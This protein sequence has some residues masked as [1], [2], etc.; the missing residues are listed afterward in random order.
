VVASALLAPVCALFG[1]GL[2]VLIRH[3]ATTIGG[4]IFGLLL[5]PVL[6]SSN[7]PWSVGVNHLMV[8]SAWQRLAE[9][10]G[11]PTALGALYPS[12]AE[13]WSV[14]A[15]WPAV[16]IGLALFAVRRRDV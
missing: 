7:Q 9:T 4:A 5:L 6:F 8:L 12:L 15:L 3:T 1:L 10:Y 14:Y 16:T 2:G 11:P 13:A